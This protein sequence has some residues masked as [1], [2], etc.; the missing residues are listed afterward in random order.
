MG[1][2]D[3]KRQNQKAPVTRKYKTRYPKIL[4]FTAFV[5][6]AI[7]AWI[8]IYEKI[9]VEKDRQPA[10]LQ[11]ET[12]RSAADGAIEQDRFRILQGGWRRPDG[13]YIIEITQIDGEGNIQAAYY[14]PRPINV[15]KARASQKDNRIQIFIELRDVGYPGATYALNYDRQRDVLTGIYYQPSVDQRFEV[16]FTRTD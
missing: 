7:A 16:L 13:G 5:G 6:F 9:I 14:N 1:S 8:L 10:V 12:S 3:S 2:T 15:S 11:S 4:Y